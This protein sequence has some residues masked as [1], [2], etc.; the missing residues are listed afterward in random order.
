MV[1]KIF[2]CF[3][4]PDSFTPE[5][6]R[7][8]VVATKKKIEKIGKCEAF[9]FQ[10]NSIIVFYSGENFQFNTAMFQP[11]NMASYDYKDIQLFFW[12]DTLN[13][14]LKQTSL[15]NVF[16]VNNKNLSLNLNLRIV[17]LLSLYLTL[18]TFNIQSP[19]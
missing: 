6:T 5:K 1:C 16:K 2:F 14:H 13:F 9:F 15:V 11:T 17:S 12:P 8:E 19:I 10:A 18:N 7:R 4:F 3:E